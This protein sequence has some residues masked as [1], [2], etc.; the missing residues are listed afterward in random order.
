MSNVIRSITII[1]IVLGLGACGLFGG[2]FEPNE[3]DVG[4]SSI[5]ADDSGAAG[6]ETVT[7]N[8][9]NNGASV[10]DVVFAVVISNGTSLSYFSDVVIYESTVDLE[11]NTPTTVIVTRAEIDAYLVQTSTSYAD[12]SYYV[13][14]ILDPQD[15]LDDIDSGNDQA[16]SNGEYFIFN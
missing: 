2:L 5:T 8:F 4:V 1:G 10:T 11:Y 14:V 12:G 3:I 9:I 15:R 16:V 6:I 7:I 13:G